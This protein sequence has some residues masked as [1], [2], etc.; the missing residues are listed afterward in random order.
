MI[1]FSK[2]LFLLCA[3]F[4]LMG[5]SGLRGQADEIKISALFRG[6]L[7]IQVL[8][9][10][11]QHFLI[12]TIHGY[13]YGVMNPIPGTEQQARFEVSSSVNYIVYL[14]AP[15][16]MNTLGGHLIDMRNLGYKI[17]SVGTHQVG[18]NLVLA[19]ATLNPSTAQVLGGDHILISPGI[20]GNAGSV[21]SNRF[22]LDFDIGTPEIR[23]LSGMPPLIEQFV[24]PG[25]YS[26]TVLLLASSAP[27]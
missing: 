21:E 14:E 23:V 5:V 22:I 3:L 12:N 27:T 10:G 13:K 2:R 9:G 8:S 18:T 17:T 25:T 4:T 7:E 1:F 6:F 26:A 24:V 20:K 15:W 16:A 11:N 19:N